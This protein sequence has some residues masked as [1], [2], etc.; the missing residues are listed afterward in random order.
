[1]KI[2]EFIGD[3]GHYQVVETEDGH[4]TLKSEYFDE[5]CHSTSGAW[6]ETKYNYFEGTKVLEKYC[7]DEI[8]ELTIFEVGFALGLGPHVVFNELEK[9]NIKKK[10]TFI[11]C[12]LD[13]SFIKWTLNKSHFSE[14]LK[15]KNAKI[16]ESK[17]YFEVHW[18]NFSL[19]I[20]K[21]DIENTMDVISLITDN[22]IDCVFHDPFSP[23]KN[24]NLW[25]VEFFNH[26]KIFL[27]NDVILSTY[28]SAVR[29]RKA[30][31]KSGFYIRARKGFGRK[32][33]MTL[34]SLDS[35]F[36][37][38]EVMKQVENANVEPFI[39]NEMKDE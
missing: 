8:L 35:T 30:L 18:K 13:L 22:K 38:Q 14:Y 32:R 39:K 26:L 15:S 6:E 31:L 17:N 19:F 23:N 24:P 25:T 9:L 21:G 28:S 36:A 5:A 3:L 33:T 10:V 7:S 16:T 27:K 12:E 20:I 34:A 4:E 11:S 1:M 2:K 29:F 37:D